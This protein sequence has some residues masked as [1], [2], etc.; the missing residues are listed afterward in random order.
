MYESQKTIVLLSFQNSGIAALEEEEAL[1][2]AGEEAPVLAFA[3]MCVRLLLL[4]GIN[5]LFWKDS[6]TI[7][8]SQ[9]TIV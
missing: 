8:F 4:I 3:S 5:S 1:P 7:V 9:K 2:A 6:K